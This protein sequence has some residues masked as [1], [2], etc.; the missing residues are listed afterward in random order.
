MSAAEEIPIWIEGE[1]DGF[2]E[3][4]IKIILSREAV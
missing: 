3:V 4:T 1:G 2:E